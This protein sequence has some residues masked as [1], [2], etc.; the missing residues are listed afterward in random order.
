MKHPYRALAAALVLSLCAQGQALAQTYPSKLVRIVNPF[1]TGGPTDPPVRWIAQKLSETWG[2]PVIVDFKGGASGNIGAD[3]VAKSPADGYTLLFITSSF[4][5]SAVT[6]ANLP[7]DP[8]KDFYPVTPV[9]SGP[10]ILVVNAAVPARNVKEFI[11]LAKKNNGKM[12]YG[13]SGRGGPLHLYMELFKT[14]AGVDVLHVPYKG[15]G[16]AL[17]DVLAGRL[18]AMFVGLPAAV[19]HLKAGKL[20]A[21]GNSSLERAQSLPDLPTIDEQGL[22]GFDGGSRYGVL[23][24]ARTPTDTVNRIHA[25]LVKVLFTPETKKLFNDFGIEPISS[26]PPEYA[27]WI[28]SQIERWTQVARTAGVQP[29]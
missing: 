9:T 8:V 3:F 19:P 27:A 12:S 16:P 29:E 20:F 23:A 14:M 28:K 11:A 5:L 6:S 22:K 17:A 26:S 18:D 7:F 25:G 13:S 1:A 21:I 24:P 10:T 2:Q 4:V 15:A